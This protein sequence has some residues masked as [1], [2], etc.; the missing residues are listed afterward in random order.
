MTFTG[1]LVGEASGKCEKHHLISFLH[2][3][4]SG[5]SS[6]QVWQCLHANEKYG[7]KK[8]LKETEKPT[9][10][11]NGMDVFEHNC[12]LSRVISANY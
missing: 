1:S 5:D 11:L 8:M 12:L 9:V 7:K 10:N 6:T 4:A 2:V 3:T